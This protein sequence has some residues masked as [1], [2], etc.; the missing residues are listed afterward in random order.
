MSDNDIIQRLDNIENE[1][2]ELKQLINQLLKTT[3]R[4]D[5]HISFVENTYETL[6]YP[7]N[8]LKNSVEKIFPV[9]KKENLMISPDD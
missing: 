4:M 1:I 7:L 8:V 5:G 3:T 2:K 6:S 9:E